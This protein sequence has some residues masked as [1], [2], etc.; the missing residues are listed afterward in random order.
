[1]LNFGS[2]E[3][4]YPGHLILS[5][6]FERWS[7]IIWVGQSRYRWADLYWHICNCWFSEATELP[8]ILLF[9]NKQLGK[10]CQIQCYLNFKRNLKLNLPQEPITFEHWLNGSLGCGIILLSAASPV[11]K[12]ICTMYYIVIL[13]CL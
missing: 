9:K 6:Y 13:P 1:M 2:I 8:T 7:M 5:N 12:I 3:N 4:L 11:N 10:L